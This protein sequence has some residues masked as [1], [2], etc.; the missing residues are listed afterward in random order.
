MSEGYKKPSL[1]NYFCSVQCPIGQKYV[2]L[3][4]PKELPGIVLELLAS[5]NAVQE[6]KELLV[7]IACDGRIS[8]TEVE[9][10][11]AIQQRLERIS[12]TVEA[13]QLW[14]EKMVA[15]G[16]VDTHGSKE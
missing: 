9:D 1:C 6:K 15:T 2:P 5:L 7:D 8:K 12:I 13:L 14:M 11:L 3:V 16:A 10:F 4:E